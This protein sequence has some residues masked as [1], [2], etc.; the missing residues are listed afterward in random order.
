[1]TGGLNCHLGGQGG[2]LRLPITHQG[3]RSLVSGGP[4]WLGCWVPHRDPRLYKYVNRLPTK[5]AS[6]ME[7]K[8]KY[9]MLGPLIAAAS[10]SLSL[11][12]SLYGPP[13]WRKCW[14]MH[15]GNSRSSSKL[16]IHSGTNEINGQTNVQDD[17]QNS[18][19]DDGQTSAWRLFSPTGGLVPLPPLRVG[20]ESTAVQL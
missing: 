12:L 3:I 9:V 18:V 11:S 1:M 2:R 10:L 4:L 20:M 5:S 13:S 16:R 8:S 15:G 17:G 19:Q 14:K 7:V 6:Y